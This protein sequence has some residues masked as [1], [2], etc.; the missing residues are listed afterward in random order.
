MPV[1][2][3]AEIHNAKPAGRPCRL[4]AGDGLFVSFRPKGSKPW[5]MN[6]R[7]QGEERALALGTCPAVKLSDARQKART[8]AQ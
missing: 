4:A 8:K 5:R 7:S 3:D 6:F 1:S 2:A